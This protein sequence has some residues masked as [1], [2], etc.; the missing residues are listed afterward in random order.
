MLDYARSWAVAKQA[1]GAERAARRVRARGR[2]RARGLGRRL[3]GGFT[4]WAEAR[5]QAGVWC[6]GPGKVSRP[7]DRA[8][9]AGGSG[10]DGAIGPTRGAGLGRSVWAGAGQ[11]V[12]QEVSR[13]G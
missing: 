6:N 7:G 8:A 12:G 4:V 3:A 1:G 2:A 9:Q 10:C 11:R 13:L 5:R